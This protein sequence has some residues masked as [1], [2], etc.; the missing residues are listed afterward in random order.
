[1]LVLTTEGKT[2]YDEKF[3]HGVNIIRGT[4]SSGKSTI[5]HL[6][7]YA[8]G[9]DYT[10]FVAE[11]HQCEKVMVEVCIDNAT[12]T[13]E[14]RLDRDGEG[15][16]RSRQGMT[17]Y[18]GRLDEALDGGCEYNCF[19]YNASA[20]TRSFS[21][22]LFEIMGMP[23]VQGDSN[24]TMN[25]LLRLMYVD[26]E[27]PTPSLFQYLQFDSQTTRETVAELLLGI[28][29]EELYTAKRRVKVLGTELDNI[30]TDIRS[31]ENILSP[32]QRSTDFVRSLIEEKNEEID[33]LTASI[34][35]MRQGEA[36]D[37]QQKKTQT[38]LQKAEVRKLEKECAQ[39]EEDIDMLQHDI[40]DSLMFAD[41]ISRKQLALRHS[42]STR[43]I[44]GSLQLEYCPECLSPLPKNV[45]EG[46][47]HLCRQ[48][49]DSYDGVTQA[50][51]LLAELAF[52]KQETE[53]IIRTDKQELIGAK[54]RLKAKKAKRRMARHALD[55][56]L[57]NVR[58]SHTEAIEDMIY[59]KGICKGELLQ[60]YTMLEHAEKY[61]MLKDEKQ[62]Q[63]KQ[64]AAVN[65]IIA[66]KT[67]QQEQ[68][69]NTVMRKIQEHGV[70][71]LHRDKQSQKA[72]ANAKACDFM[73]DFPGNM[74]FLH[75]RTNKC[76]ASSSFFL[77]L[78]ARFALMF[79]S[80]DIDWM[81]YPRF[82]FADNM[83]DKGIEMERAQKFQQ[84]LIRRLGEY[85]TDDFQV[86]YT[87]SY[88]TP[89]L[90][91]SSLVVGDSYDISH[92]SLRNV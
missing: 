16:I 42:A 44:L 20:S 77:K 87:T 2:A 86:I 51:R 65:A 33:R 59:K 21:N 14:R 40:E 58:S 46:T 11:V 54:A 38:E 90:D 63:E 47:C 15:R 71:F 45:G 70:Y 74:V 43:R 9:G 84:T 67:S 34:A 7:F 89:E 79:A 49:V 48:K 32:D 37:K 25:Q 62:M 76:S 35:L 24:I 6:L 81:R 56:M 10:Q 3:H 78:V 92:K 5:T 41:E 13:L 36:T 60:Y 69:R 64:I 39:I 4:N 8:L 91:S 27:S 17:I 55:D 23:V 12:I 80:L 22:V 83:E 29:D 72:F 66:Q 61:K 19:G 26:Q 85:P 73:V 88:I 18:W 75:D 30:K 52:Q 31:L 57:G 82:I 68:R 1:M 53:E 28:F 50:K